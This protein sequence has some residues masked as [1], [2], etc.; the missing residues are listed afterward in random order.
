ML[1]YFTGTGTIFDAFRWHPEEPM[2]VYVGD[3]NG[4]EPVRHYELPAGVV[5]HVSNAFEENG[6]VVIDAVLYTDDS[7]LRTIQAA[8]RGDLETIRPGK[9]TRIR[10]G[11]NGKASRE[12]LG[13]MGL[14][15]PRI[16]ERRDSLSYTYCYGT[17]DGEKAYATPEIVKIDTRKQT[18]VKHLVRDM[19]TKFVE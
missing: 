15:F 14:E 19:F 2:T 16:N 10:L 11:K 1:K 4:H 13:D 6:D 17:V 9:L 5:F 8:F 12:T 7:P 18:S 3:R